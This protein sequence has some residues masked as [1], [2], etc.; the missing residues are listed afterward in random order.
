MQKKVMAPDPEEN[1][2]ARPICPKCLRPRPPD[3]ESCPK[4]GLVFSLWDK[5]DEKSLHGSA[6]PDGTAEELWMQVTNNP[7]DE[8]SHHAF[9]A[10]CQGKG[11]LDE[12]AWKYRQFLS[13]NP[14][15][16]LGLAYRE[17]IIQ[18]AQLATPPRHKKPEKPKSYRVLKIILALGAAALLLALFAVRFFIGV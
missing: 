13:T 16:D 6:A 5:R 18:M 8:A 12:A 9:L 17:K 10:Y 3:G 1:R 14:E 2:P 7:D 4:C 15:S 11:I